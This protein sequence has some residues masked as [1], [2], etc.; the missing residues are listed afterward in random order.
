MF[1]FVSG[2]IFGGISGGILSGISGG[3]FGGIS[4][5][6]F[7]V[8]LVTLRSQ[9]RLLKQRRLRWP[10]IMQLPSRFMSIQQLGV[11]VRTQMED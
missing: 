9:R 8:G 7:G 10:Q 2:G 1:V 4:G 5:G 3:I 11:S 6:I